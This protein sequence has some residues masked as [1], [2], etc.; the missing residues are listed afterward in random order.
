MDGVIDIHTHVISTDVTRYPLA[1]LGGKQS[2]WS[3]ERPLNADMLL[4]AMDQAGVVK[5]AVVQASTAYG[6]DN[7]Y[8]AHSV[9]THPD[10]FTG[11][12]CIDLFAADAAARFKWWTDAGLTGMRLFTTGSTAPGQADWLADARTFPIWELAEAANLPVC[13]QMRPEGVADLLRL[14]Q[15]FRGVPIIL[16][17]LARP[18]LSDGP[19][20][21]SA[22]WLFELAAYPNVFLKLTSR[23]VEQA[24][25]GSSTAQDFFP[26]LV[27]AFGADRIA[28]GSNFPAHAGPMSRLLQEAEH[29]L[30]CLSP[31]DR[32]WIFSQ[33]ACRLYPALAR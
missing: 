19:P 13:L 17:H 15:R 26:K 12:F 16:D 20:Y 9:A 22:Q 27:A 3:R 8:L 25:Q 32:N 18:T 10:R 6:F 23:T 2:D 30:V 24:S 4:A 29:A 7:S 1:P 14:L 31:R 33:T 21:R 11:V 28:W 5:S